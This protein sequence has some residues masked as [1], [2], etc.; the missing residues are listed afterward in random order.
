MD[1]FVEVHKRFVLFIVLA[2]W[3]TLTTVYQVELL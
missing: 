3:L 1:I 2:F